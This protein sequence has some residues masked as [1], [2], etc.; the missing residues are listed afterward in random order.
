MLKCEISKKENKVIFNVEGPIRE[1][2]TDLSI[3]MENLVKGGM[4]LEFLVAAL[5]SAVNDGL[6][7]EEYN[8]C[9]EVISDLLKAIKDK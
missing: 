7:Q 8:H 9:C 3:L 6:D 5:V 2:T 4:K 1:C